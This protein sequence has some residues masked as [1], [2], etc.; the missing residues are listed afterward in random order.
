MLGTRP[1]YTIFPEPW[2]CV[3]RPFLLQLIWIFPFT[4][5]LPS[6]ISKLVLAYLLNRPSKL[7]SRTDVPRPFATP[8]MALSPTACTL[9]FHGCR[10]LPLPQARKPPHCAAFRHAL[11]WHLSWHRPGPSSPVQ[12]SA[13]GSHL[14]LA[15]CSYIPVSSGRPCNAALGLHSHRVH[16]SAFG[17]RMR[18]HNQL[19]R[20]WALLLRKA[21]WHVQTEENIPLIDDNTKRADL[22]AVSPTGLT[23]VCAPQVTATSDHTPLSL[24]LSLRVPLFRLLL[25]TRPACIIP[26]WL[27]IFLVDAASCL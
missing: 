18:R 16:H 6:I 23:T 20:T 2:L 8:S 9:T 12:P 13:S 14:T 11:P 26:H 25:T 3:L 10:L 21:G 22:V 5:R 4:W 15:G 27:A 19:C 24:S 7:M 1:P 17:P